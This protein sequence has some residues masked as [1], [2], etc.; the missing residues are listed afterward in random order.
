MLM[1]MRIGEAEKANK[2]DFK[3]FFRRWGVHN[4]VT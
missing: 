3:G 4:L 2:T 1:L